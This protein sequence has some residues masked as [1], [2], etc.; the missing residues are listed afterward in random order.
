[1]VAG[2]P[3]HRFS[4]KSIG[5]VTDLVDAGRWEQSEAD[6][7]FGKQFRTR[8]ELEVDLSLVFTAEFLILVGLTLL[9]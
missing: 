9:S 8:L 2:W 3:A 7:E 4:I 1:V 5:L 6:N